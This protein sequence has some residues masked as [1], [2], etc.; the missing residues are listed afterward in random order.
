MAV[1]G[2]YNIEL[3]GVGYMILSDSYICDW[4]TPY[5]AV[6]NVGAIP[7][8]ESR[9]K[10]IWEKRY[11]DFS[12]GGGQKYSE[13]ET[14]VPNRYIDSQDID[15]STPGEFTL[16]KDMEGSYTATATNGLLHT[17]LDY[18]WIIDG[19]N[20]SYF[21]G[22]VWSAPMA[23]GAPSTPYSITDDGSQVYVAAG[24]AATY[25][26]STSPASWA[27]YSSGSGSDAN[28]MAYIN[29]QLYG[30]IGQW[31]WKI[32]PGTDNNSSI[33]DAGN[34]WNLIS[35]TEYDNQIA[36]GGYKGGYA[37]KS[38]VW[39]SDGTT[40][41]TTMLIDDLPLGFRLRGM[42]S[43]GDI[44]WIYG[45]YEVSNGVRGVLFAYTNGSLLYQGDFFEAANAGEA[46]PQSFSIDTAPRC[47]FAQGQFVYF[48]MNERSGLWRYDLKSGGLSRSF[49]AAT[50][51]NTVTGAAYYKG[52]TYLAYPATSAVGCFVQSSNYKQEG[53][54]V[55]SGT[56]F[57]LANDKIA[58]SIKLNQNRVGGGF[59]QRYLGDALPADS[60]PPWTK[61]FADGPNESINS[62]VLKAEGKIYYYRN[63][64]T[65]DNSV[66]TSLY[67]RVKMG[68]LGTGAGGAE[69][70]ICDG[71]KTI[72]LH[73]GW[74]YKDGDPSQ[75]QSQ[76]FLTDGVQ[77]VEDWDIQWI[78]TTVYHSY[79]ITLKGNTAQLYIDNI[80]V[81]D[82][83]S[84]GDGGTKEVRF[85]NETPVGFFMQT[86]Y[87]DNV[88]YTTEGTDISLDFA[89]ID[90]ST[91]GKVFSRVE[92]LS[93]TNGL[94]YDLY[95]TLLQSKANVLFP[96]IRLY[97]NFQADDP[98]SIKDVTARALPVVPA[99][100]S[101]EV[102]VDISN[103][104]SLINGESKE[105]VAQELYETLLSI[106]EHNTVVGF[107]DV[108]Y[109]ISSTPTTT[110]VVVDRINR[111]N[112]I[113]NDG[114]LS[115]IVHLRLVEF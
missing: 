37:A 33:F 25:A 22:S 17:G 91:D 109:D 83:V 80:L 102:D 71:D 67:A 59:P 92:P 84:P 16:M 103:T 90:I 104:M 112:V 6:E 97:H 39:A 21:N 53:R 18:L 43:Y 98:I 64:T 12:G 9:S 82:N 105:V 74:D 60:N 48:G 89:E 7:G 54:I 75:F 3:D 30:T 76:V 73:F 42:L 8:E 20:I 56:S 15:V 31:L 36:F 100:R 88:L 40:A 29:G 106:R 38:Y 34:G 51:N 41:G 65:L 28:S 32:M 111:K 14:A 70:K 68:E 87:W 10:F 57:G 50:S 44:L 66:G 13:T 69:I 114:K 72:Y 47:A 58:H 23:T 11:S 35:V 1:D 4:D 77:G 27:L 52:K 113:I 95:N 46:N 107:K 2:L 115:N 93:L 86:S 101:W 55:L 81:R 61:V 26:G 5:M 99:K 49:S 63:D 110:K 85:G 96:G 78:D 79:K 94:E 62:S 45:G 24:N 108:D 19:A